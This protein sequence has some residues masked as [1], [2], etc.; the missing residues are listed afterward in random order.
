MN[1]KTAIRYEDDALYWPNGDV[2]AACEGIDMLREYFRQEEELKLAPWRAAK[3]GEV[4]VF[5]HGGVNTT[6]VAYNVGSGPRFY[7]DRGVEFYPDAEKAQVVK[8]YRVWPKKG[9]AG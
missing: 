6:E 8:A 9:S 3:D 2:I 5:I 4:W 7:R 1:N